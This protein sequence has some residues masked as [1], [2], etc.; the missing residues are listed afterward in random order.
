LLSAGEVVEEKK[1]HDRIRYL[2]VEFL[3][4]RGLLSGTVPATRQVL[5]ACLKHLAM[6][7][8]ETLLVNLEDLW[9]ETEYQNIP[10][11]TTEHANWRH[12]ARYRLD[13]IRHLDEVVR[14]VHEIDRL[15]K[16]SGAAG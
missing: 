6:E 13:E 12:K 15:R 16:H 7:N 1:E 3:R 4:R 9:L 5:E 10:G 11:T 2:L 14:I 8:D